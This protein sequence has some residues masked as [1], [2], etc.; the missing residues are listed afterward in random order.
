MKQKKHLHTN[1]LKFIVEK[2]NEEI[3]E[4][5]EEETNCPDEK[6]V[7]EFDE[8]MGY[9]EEE[10]EEN[11][12]VQDEEETPESV[13]ALIKEFRSLQKIYKTKTNGSIRSKRK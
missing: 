5:P 10:E 9:G 11:D 7:D 6:L 2:Y 12:E 1:F 3:Q 4:H 8:I 13:D